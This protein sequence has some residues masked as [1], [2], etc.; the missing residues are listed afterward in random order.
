[1]SHVYISDGGHFENL[2]VFELLRRNCEVILC[3][4]AGED[5]NL[6]FED[7]STL[8]SIA[9][10]VPQ[11]SNRD[12]YCEFSLEQP[13][14]ENS[15]SHVHNFVDLFKEKTSLVHCKSRL[16]RIAYTLHVKKAG[17]DEFFEKVSVFW[18]TGPTDINSF[19]REMESSL[20]GNPL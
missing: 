3:F 2:A 18:N 19:C 10:E 16:I 7:V 1:M 11:N 12:W 20:L 14:G 6:I 17:T 4:D 13:D 8:L 9:S 15:S 5:P